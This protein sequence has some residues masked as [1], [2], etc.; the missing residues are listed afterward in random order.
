MLSL[1]AQ[2]KH[3]LRNVVNCTFKVISDQLNE[4]ALQSILAVLE[5]GDQDEN[6]G[7]DEDGDEN[8]SSDEEDKDEVEESEEELEESDNEEE[9]TVFFY[10]FLRQ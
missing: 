9:V 7:E 3:I 1:L 6:E 10:C 5:D 4:A 8:D 2:N